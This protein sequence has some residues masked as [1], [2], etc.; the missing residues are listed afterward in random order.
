MHKRLALAYLEE[1][2]IAA[3]LPSRSGSREINLLHEGAGR[4]CGKSPASPS[5]S[6][7]PNVWRTN[8]SWRQNG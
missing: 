1:L 3:R 6:G 4:R 2:A 5:P 8:C 7:R